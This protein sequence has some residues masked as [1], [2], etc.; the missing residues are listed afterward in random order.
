MEDRSIP[1]RKTRQLARRWIFLLFAL[2]LFAC[3]VE[4]G[5][6]H[7]P[8]SSAPV[9]EGFSLLSHAM[10]DSVEEAYL[11]Y[12]SDE[13]RVTGYLFIA[14]YSQL[15]VEPCLIFNHGGVNGV[16]EA[17]KA[18]CRWL[19]KQGFLVFAPSYRG[20]AGS[21]G[22]VEVAEGEVDDVL[23]AMKLLETHPGVDPGKFVMLGTSHGA[24]ISVKVAARPLG[25]KL[26]HGVV[27]AYGVMDIYSWY[28]YLLDNGFDTSDSLSV[29]VYGTGPQDKPEAF[30]K[31]QALS[32]I[33]QLGPAP[34]MLVQGGKD[35]IVPQDQARTMKAA[36]DKAGRTQ[37]LLRV[38]PEG[39]H[40]FLFWDDPALHSQE[41]LAA[42]EKAWR[43]ILHF[44]RTAVGAA[45]SSQG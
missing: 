43:E 30:A 10:T 8:G 21:Q 45:S 19:A 34:I 24:L 39:A 42:S 40:G 18:K 11:G 23:A 31:R 6:K 1:V 3:K 44:L 28:Q 25:K 15:E 32:L 29:R 14:P 33:D 13:L 20:E 16:S 2:S 9:E 12:A 38:Y 4:Q 7:R 35:R 26:L 22:R 37:D 41:E 27:A 36:L 5:K 17:V